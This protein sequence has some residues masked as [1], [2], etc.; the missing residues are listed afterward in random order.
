MPLRWGSALRVAGIVATGI[1]TIAIASGAGLRAAKAD[2][3]DGALTL[4]YQN[5]P[6]LNSQR[7]VAIGQS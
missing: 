1:G 6:Q 5:N 4:A 7:A 2:T 3:L